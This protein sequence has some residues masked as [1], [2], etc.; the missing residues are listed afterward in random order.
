MSKS[1]HMM[2][3]SDLT[4]VVKNETVDAV[5]EKTGGRATPLIWSVLVA[6]SVMSWICVCV[7]SA[8]MW[9]LLDKDT[10]I[11]RRLND[12]SYATMKFP[13]S[14]LLDL[15]VLYVIWAS[16]H[17]N[18]LRYMLLFK[19]CWMIV[20]LSLLCMPMYHSRFFEGLSPLKPWTWGNPSR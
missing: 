4:T 17:A 9:Y 18:R 13:S 20:L 10:S 14:V 16:G 5:V 2:E 1:I 6:S 19:V 15:P 8:F 7:F 11:F 12:V 3:P